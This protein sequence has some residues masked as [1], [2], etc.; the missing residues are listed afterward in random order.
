MDKGHT[1]DQN[2]S[3]PLR[4]RWYWILLAMLWIAG[5][6][7]SVVVFRNEILDFRQYG[8]LGVFLISLLA[9]ATIVAFIPSVPVIFALGGILNP[10]LVGLTAGAGEAIGEL[11]GYLA[12]RTGHAFFIKGR[13]MG[14]GRLG[15]LYSRLQKWVETRGSLALFLSSVI[16][17]PFFSVI[18]ATAGAL[19]FPAWKFLL[20]VWAGKTVKWTVVSLVGWGTISY[21]LRRLGITL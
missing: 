14:T 16:F 9:S 11:T 17:N 20:T 18:G 8:Y 12:G 10:F 3:L 5:I 2:K 7:T 1:E 19:R 6:V 21:I 15:G 4:V 13:P